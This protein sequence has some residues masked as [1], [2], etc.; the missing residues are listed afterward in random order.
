MLQVVAHRQKDATTGLKIT[1]RQRTMSGLI[2]ALTGQTKFVLPVM[3]IGHVGWSQVD[4]TF[5]GLLSNRKV[6]AKLSKSYRE[7]IATWQL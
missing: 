4:A 3:L 2:G 7:V 1:S 6:I 5:T